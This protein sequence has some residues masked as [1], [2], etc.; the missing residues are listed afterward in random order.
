MRLIVGLGN[1]GREY[2]K[3]RHNAGFMVVDR[4]AVRHGLSGAKMKFHSGLLTGL[5]GEHKVALIQPMTFMNR[6]GIAVREAMDFYK[7]QPA[8]VMVVVDDVAL[9]LAKLRVRGGGGAGGHNGLADI[10]KHLGTTKYPRLRVGIDPPPPRVAQ[11]DWV[12][13]RFTPEQL[14]AIEPA[15]ERACDC[16]EM[17]LG[18]P[19]EAVM[20]RFNAEE[21]NGATKRRSDEGGGEERHEG[22]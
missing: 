21:S 2:E 12:L 10:E 20:N 8:E 3:T 16:V 11:S 18:E 13:G 5:I 15:V 1:P 7:V 6:C 22:T 4:L 14:E 19:M 9:P 17:W